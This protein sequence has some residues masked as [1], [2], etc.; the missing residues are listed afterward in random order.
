MS[1]SFVAGLLAGLFAGGVLGTLFV[2]I[3][4]AGSDRRL[5]DHQWQDAGWTV[6]G[7]AR[8]SARAWAESSMRIDLLL[9][10]R[11]A[12]RYM[13]LPVADVDDIEQEMRELVRRYGTTWGG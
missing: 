2:A 8:P 12:D 10:I 1:G 13:D 3:I 4:A 11:D 9:G 7:A 5:L 6:A